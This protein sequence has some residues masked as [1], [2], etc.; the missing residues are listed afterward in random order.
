[1][2]VHERGG[3]GRQKQ[4]TPAD[5]DAFLEAVRREVGI[6]RDGRRG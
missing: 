3:Y 1:M 5:R 2:N 6:Q 4:A